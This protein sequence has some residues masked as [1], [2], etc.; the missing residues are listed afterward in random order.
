MRACVCLIDD[1]PLIRE[2]ASL[3]LRG[4]GYEVILA[5]NGADGLAVIAARQPDVI[6]TDV[7]M[8]ETDGLEFLPR[9]KAR[10]PDLPVIAMSGGGEKGDQL[11]LHLAS[12]FGASACLAKPFSG[13]KLLAAVERALAG[14]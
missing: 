13:S 11:Y 6:V 9:L 4:G 2:A 8:P 7:L 1:D 14:A 12:R 10:Y 5:E 3:V